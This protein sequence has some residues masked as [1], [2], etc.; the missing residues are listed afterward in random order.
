MAGIY[1]RE[2]GDPNGFR[3]FTQPFKGEYLI[4][5]I[6]LQIRQ[7]LDLATIW[8]TTVDAVQQLLGCDRALIYQFAADKSGQVVVEAVPDPQWSLLGQTVHDACFEADWLKPYDE[9]QVRAIADVSAANLTPCHAEFLAWFQ[10]K[11]S[12][13]VPVLCEAQLWGLLI[14]HHCSAPRDWQSEE[15]AT[16]QQVAIHVG[17]AIQQADLVAQL[18]AAK[19][20]LEAQTELALRQSRDQ[21]LQLAAIVASSQ[22]AIISKTPEG[23]ITSWN[24]AAERL[25]GYSA[26]EAIGQPITLIIPPDLQANEALI[27]Q[28]LHQGQSIETYETQRQCKDGRLV[29]VALTISPIQDETG[30]LIGASKIARDITA[31][32]QAQSALQDQTATLQSFYNSSPLMMGVVELSEDDILN[33]SNNQ[34]TATFFNTTVEALAGQ[35]ISALGVPPDLIETWVR[36]Y[37]QSQALGQ[38]VQFD[39]AHATDTKSAWLS[40][41]VSY[42]RLGDRQR[43]RFSYVAADI[44]DRKQAETDLHHFNMV[45]ENALEGIARLDLA[46]QYISVNRVYAAVCGYEPN[47]LLGQAWTTT[48]YADDLP[49]LEAAYEAMRVTG[50]IEAEA[51][52]VRQDGSLFYKQVT[53]IADY[54]TQGVF[55]GHYCFLKDISERKQSEFERQQVEADLR[56]SEARWQFALEGSGDGV[57]DWNSQTNTVFF[58]RQW[59][60]MLGYGEDEV[61]TTLDEW[62]GRVHPDDLEQC[63]A[64]LQRHFSGETPIYQNE[65][66][67]RCKDGS[68]KWILDRGKAI[69]WVEPGVPLRVIGTH[70]D[71]SNHKQAEADLRASEARWQFALEGPGDGVW[72]WNPQTN[73]VFFSRQ[74]KA[75]LGYDEDEVG[76]TLDEWSGRVH[77]DDLEQCYATLQRHFSGET[78]IYRNEYR[79]RCKDGSYKWVLDR[80]KVIEWTETGEPLRVIGTLS[81]ITERRQIQESL[82]EE[83]S[84]FIGG[85][86]I[87]IRWGAASGWPIEYISPNVEAELGYP[88][89]DL[90]AENISFVSLIHADD[91]ERVHAEVASSTAAR[92]PSY[93]QTYRLRHA[94]GDFRW[95]EDF[96]RVIYTADGSVRQFLGYIQDQTERKQADLALQLSEARYRSI[97]ETTL[98]GVWMLDAEGKTTFVNQQMADMLG[99]SVEAMAGTALMDFIAAA[100]QAQAQAYL[101]RRQQRVEEKHPFKFRRQD[102]AVLWAMVSATPLLDDNQDYAGCIG[103]L[104]DITQLITMQEALK[105]S[106]MQLGSVLDSSLDGIMA[107]RSV[108]DEQGTIVDFEWLLSNPTACDLVG[109]TEAELI[110]K[111]LLDEM[112]GNREE[113]LFEGYV[114]TVETG[115]PYQREF[116]Y[117]HEGIESWFENIAVKLG[118]GFAVTFRNVTTL[119]QSEQ[120]LQQLNQQLEDR[121]ADLAQRHV[122]MV[123][124]SEISDFLQ[125][126][127]TV[128]EA[129]HTITNLVETLFPNC[130]GRI[131]ITRASLNRLEMVSSWGRQLYSNTDFEPHRC[132]G[133]RR[134]RMHYV[135]QDRLSLRCHHVPANDATATL[136]VPMMAQGKTLGLLYLSTETSGGLPESKQQLART[137]AEQVG[138][139]IANLKL[140][141]T[142]QHQSIRDPLMGLYNRRYLEETLTQEMMRAQ[143]KQRSIGVIMIDIDH[144]KQFNDTFGHDA[145]DFVLQ[146][147]GA[148]L[149]ENVRNS[150]IACRYGGEEMTLILPETTLAETAARAELLRAA[151]SQLHPHHHG[152]GLGT[153]T[154]SFGVA[155]FPQ[156]GSTV[157]ALIKAADEALY[158]AKAAGRNQV[159]T[160]PLP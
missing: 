20:D 138:M 21:R 57:W 77:P 36:H 98:E 111:R 108:R 71:I 47:N 78:P 19:V 122:E 62:S 142:L 7:S 70:S 54:D 93:T 144:F 81:D 6:A 83:R 121:V 15:I 125:A 149:K 148:L 123:T 17:I 26:A 25:F 9:R 101:D 96:T 116:H 65:H 11:A 69:E 136:C 160:S 12:L 2:S 115:E 82:K 63:Y 159:S 72:D 68:Y 99:Y 85:P 88:P 10:V 156:H 158:R 79:I 44:S 27:C 118:D 53:M 151:I 143:R 120:A 42:I 8:Q 51:R 146:Q 39:Y 74:W 128:E 91:A 1:G 130:A 133:L 66:R 139:A 147:V 41:V 126:C 64:D 92:K 5:E 49:T 141:E 137:L 95:I 58:S 16:L 131:F 103:L 3:S 102:Q 152:Q 67:V 13:V 30:V 61:G 109:R 46:G 107:F 114:R 59:K 38:T 45:L 90:L 145:G 124:L 50:K 80:G 60:A 153:I 87:V 150:D 135:G 132:W 157:S 112:P 89:A 154:A 48:V 117:D 18:Q 94:N 23:I 35:W 14:A 56:A 24:R 100:D 119:K 113:G 110:G 34:A 31:Q 40:V 127:S 33:V 55:V 129:C 29:E 22:D 32:R 76:T 84:L 86:T 134:G 28:H 140:Q 106:K 52:G 105:T 4:A 73:T 75:M 37:H 155:T 97:I 43:P 104:T